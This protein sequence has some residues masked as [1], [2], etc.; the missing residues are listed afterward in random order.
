M[1][2]ELHELAHRHVAAHHPYLDALR[3]GT[4][5][6]PREAVRDLVL[7][8]F[9]YSSNFIRYLTGAMCQLSEPAHRQVLLRNLA[10][11]AGDLSS[12]D[13]QALARAGI[14]PAW[15]EGCPHPVLFKRG[16]DAIGVDGRGRV[17]RTLAPE[18]RAWSQLFLGCCRGA[19]AATAIGALG[20]GTECIVGEIYRPIITAIERHF[21][22]S[23]RDVVF[24][25]L[26]CEVDD[27]HGALLSGVAA[28]LAKEPHNR[29]RLRSGVEQALFLRA[30]F[31]DAMQRRALAMTPAGH[32]PGRGP[33]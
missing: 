4:L 14:D 5:P 15:V 24:F 10:E 33:A 26:H 21:D 6:D 13:R 9:G 32:G 18:A 29:A 11:E 1:I 19:G 25:K 3:E 2:D 20:P 12:E 17:Q 23:P 16:L 30:A 7:N 27:G 31:F 28:D 8:Y 22:I